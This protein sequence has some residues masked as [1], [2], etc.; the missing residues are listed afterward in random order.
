MYIAFQKWCTI[1]CHVE[2]ILSNVSNL[3]ANLVSLIYLHQEID[4][5]GVVGLASVHVRYSCVFT[6]WERRKTEINT[7]Q[8]M[9]A[10]VPVANRLSIN[11][12]NQLNPSNRWTLKKGTLLR[13]GI[14]RLKFASTR[15]NE[16]I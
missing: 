3:I 16:K 14:H 8:F 9:N 7:A 2:G 10:D 4:H 1:A 12:V 5:F 13:H 11:S 6:P 15:R